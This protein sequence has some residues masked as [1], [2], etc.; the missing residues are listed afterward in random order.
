[1]AL[2][3][4]EGF[5]M[6]GD[7]GRTGTDLDT[8]ILRRH[9]GSILNGTDGDLITGRGG[10]G[11][12]LRFNTY[13]TSNRII[14]SRYDYTQSDTWIVGFAV[15]TGPISEGSL[16]QVF[17]STY[18]D[19]IALYSRDG[20]LYVKSYDWSLYEPVN[21]TMRPNR[22]YYIEIK[23][24]HH[25]SA[26]TIDIQVNGELVYSVTGKDTIRTSLFT[27]PLGSML[28]YSFEDECAYD[29]IY[30]CDDTGSDN[31]D[32]LGPIK[33]ETLRPDGDDGAQ[34]WSPSSGSNHFELMDSSNLWQ[35]T[36]YVE[37]NGANVDDL[38]AYNNLSKI[39]G[40]IY[41]VQVVAAAWSDTGMPQPL[42]LIC[43]SNSTVEYSNIRGVGVSIDNPLSHDFMWETDPD[44]ANAW[45]ISGI[46]A[47]SFGVR[48]V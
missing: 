4:L 17:G 26:G 22:W 31:N 33:I 34:N 12:A 40:N 38:W 37:A 9:G 44:T 28:F 14:V 41:A 25:A 29:D 18:V 46:N 19:H 48:K 42:Q 23:T 16:R 13:D 27:Y 43:D 30:I 35:N 3:L 47:A 11:V 36:D 15:L 20:T 6:Y 8:D 39:T 32:F 1:M 24:Y 2:R 7:S 21:Y 10:D 5:E 45:T